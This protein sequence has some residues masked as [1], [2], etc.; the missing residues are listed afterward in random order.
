MNDEEQHCCPR[1]CRGPTHTPEQ[2]GLGH[3]GTCQHQ[4][5]GASGDSDHSD[6]VTPGEK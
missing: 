6:V 3:P 1:L 4:S 5:H 2:R